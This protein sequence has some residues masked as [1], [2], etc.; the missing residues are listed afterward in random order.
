M[1]DI[2]VR[3][4]LVMSVHSETQTHNHARTGGPT[5]KPGPLNWSVMNTINDTCISALHWH[6]Y[7]CWDES[8]VQFT[9]HKLNWTEQAAYHRAITRQS[10]RSLR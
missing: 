7:R 2:S 6:N 4:H 5:A 9:S 3:G 8:F 10:I 1:A